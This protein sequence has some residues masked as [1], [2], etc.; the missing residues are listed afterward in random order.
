MKKLCILIAM[1]LLVP[2]C[3][4]LHS[5]PEE[6]V[7]AVKEAVMV[8]RALD[9]NVGRVSLNNVILLANDTEKLVAAGE[10]TEET[11][12]ELIQMASS[13]AKVSKRQ[14]EFMKKFMDLV[15]ADAKGKVL[16]PE[17]IKAFIEELK[18]VSPE[19][20]NFVDKLAEMGY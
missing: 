6:Y 1:A 10:M 18:K 16:K 14:S 3:A 20:Q 2:G 8:S 13:Q 11:R 9:V 12:Q 15:L 17:D 5:H 19:F 7:D 4:L